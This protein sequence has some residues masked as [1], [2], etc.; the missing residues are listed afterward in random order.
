MMWATLRLF[1]ARYRLAVKLFKLRL[2]VKRIDLAQSPLQENLNRSR[3]LGP[4]VRRRVG[5]FRQDRSGA[6]LARDQG[7]EC[8]A[9]QAGGKVAEQVSPMNG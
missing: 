9:A 6:R 8:H 1:V 7:G 4:V 3:R 2:V 5:G